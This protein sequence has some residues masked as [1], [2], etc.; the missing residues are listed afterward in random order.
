MTRPLSF[1]QPD[2]FAASRFASWPFASLEPQAYDFIM[3]DPPWHF[4]LRSVKGE[5]KSAQAQY[6]TMTLDD[7]MALPVGDLAREHCLLWLWGTAPMLRQQLACLDAWG[8]DYV[9][10]GVWV[11]QTR[12]GNRHFGTGYALRNEH[13]E[14][15]I[16]KRGEPVIASRSLRSVVFGPV[17]EHSR[18]PDEAYALAE[19]M[20]PH[21]RR[22]DVFSRE[23][24]PGWDAWGNEAGLFDGA[25]DTRSARRP[26][27]R[28]ATSTKP[29]MRSTKEPTT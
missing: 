10:K 9:T 16:A 4:S 28:V 12:L 1:I 17:R 21:G 3:T 26:D 27:A 5:G 23:Q 8:F 20:C 25:S 18:K 13:E 24:R 22:A 6:A 7:I 11:K 2:M 29:V 15:I 19:A 14:I